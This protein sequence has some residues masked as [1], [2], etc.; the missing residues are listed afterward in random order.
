MV[1]A[2]ALASYAHGAIMEKKLTVWDVLHNIE[3]NQAEVD[4]LCRRC[5]INERSVR[6]QLRTLLDS[7]FIEK[8]KIEEK[9]GRVRLLYKVKE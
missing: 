4:E 2:D 6:K 9:N 3:V 7:G 1:R 5:N 8:V